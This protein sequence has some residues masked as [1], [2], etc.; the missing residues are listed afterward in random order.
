MDSKLKKIYKKRFRNIDNIGI[1]KNHEDKAYIWNLI[2][3]YFDIN[4]GESV[5]DLIDKLNKISES[6]IDTK[7]KK[8]YGYYDESPHYE[9]YGKFEENEEE[10]KLRQEYY[11]EMKI[12]R[13]QDKER[14]KEMKKQQKIE[15]EKKER[16]EYER[17]K[18]KYGE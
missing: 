2:D 10:Y 4:D 17:L 3:P 13:E 8:I 6:T 18:Q 16:V 14:S 9:I 15:D 12:K 11:K 1:P 7:I 5:K